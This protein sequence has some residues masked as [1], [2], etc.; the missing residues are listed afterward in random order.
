[1]CL[2]KDLKKKKIESRVA[3]LHHSD[4]ICLQLSFTE[5]TVKDCKVKGLTQRSSEVVVYVGSTDEPSATF[6]WSVCWS[7]RDEQSLGVE[8][9]ETV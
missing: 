4:F 8:V 9:S 3:L 2:N 6:S 1:M 7:V 5:Q